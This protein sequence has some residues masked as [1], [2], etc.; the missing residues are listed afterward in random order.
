MSFAVV[1]LGYVGLPT[2]LSLTGDDVELIG[3]DISEARLHAIR[4]GRV[5]LLPRDVHRLHDALAADALTLTAEP[6]QLA[7]ADVVLICVPTPVDHHLTPDL[8]ALR[9]ACDTVVR[10]AKAGQTIVLTS[11]T[12][13]GC[14]RDMLVEP[15]QARGFAVGRDVFVAFSPERID[16]GVDEHRPEMTPRVVGGVT[17]QCS[18]K[19]AEVLGRTAA[20]LHMVSSPEAAEMTKLVENSFRAVN[21]ALANEFASAARELSVDVMEVIGAAAT[22][23]YGFMPFYPGPGVGGHCIPC[24]PHYLLWQLRAQRTSLPVMESAM[25]AISRRPLDVV[26]EA[27]RVLAD[28][29]KPL[30]GARV[31]VVGVA[32][33]PGVAD[34][35]ESPA[36]LILDRLITEGAHTSFTDPEIQLLRTPDG[37]ELLGHAKPD[38][39]QWDLVIVHTIHPG[40]QLDWLA[41]QPAVLDSTYRMTQLEQRHV[42]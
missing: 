14:T 37:H 13:P 18:A 12:Y 38:E 10:H 5:D 23:P 4:S 1:G 15:L 24:D 40:E 22:K 2:A 42:I 3:F 29:G 20:V 41:E 19:A 26:D 36:L 28:R 7:A 35:R 34:V 30:R 8:G 39:C 31:L 33:K 25:T 6:A 16:P 11:T 21:I 9:G 27:R 32:Y 17:A